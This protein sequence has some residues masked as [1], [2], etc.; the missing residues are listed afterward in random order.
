MPFS[1][2]R[3]RTRL[4]LASNAAPSLHIPPTQAPL[5]AIDEITK[6]LADKGK[7][8]ANARAGALRARALVH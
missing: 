2:N 5:K 4:C 3:A 7:N 6:E 8:K 1:R